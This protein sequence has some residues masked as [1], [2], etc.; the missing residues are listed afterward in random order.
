MRSSILVPQLTGHLKR[1]LSRYFL[2]KIHRNMNG[3]KAWHEQKRLKL[4]VSIAL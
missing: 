3:I 4:S 1:Y 2:H